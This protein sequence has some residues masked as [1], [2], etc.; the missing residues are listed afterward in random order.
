[1]DATLIQAVP[2]I[3]TTSL[4]QLQQLSLLFTLSLALKSTPAPKRKPLLIL[5]STP[6]LTPA[7]ESAL[8]Q[9]TWTKL[10]L[11]NHLILLNHVYDH[12]GDFASSRIQLFIL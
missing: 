2:T 10:T 5:A 12:L 7:L 3:E 9:K 6:T 4:T 1:L 8:K 11:A